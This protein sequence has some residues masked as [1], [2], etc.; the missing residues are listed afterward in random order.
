MIAAQA[1]SIEGGI[2]G[3][4]DSI[5][6]SR[7][8]RL[9]CTSLGSRKISVDA[10]Q[11]ITRRSQPFLF[12]KSR[13]SLRSASAASIFVPVFFTFVPCRRFT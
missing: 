9:A 7:F 2:C 12:L 3:S 5:A 13:M 4:L 10:H 1:Y 6:A 11:T 8:S